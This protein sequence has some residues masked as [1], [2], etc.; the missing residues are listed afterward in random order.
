MSFNIKLHYIIIFFTLIS[1]AYGGNP[2]PE[3][4][5]PSDTISTITVSGNKVTRT[6]TLL[7]MC[8]IKTGMLYDSTLIEKARRRLKES[9]LFFKVD[10]LSLK[11]SEGYRIYIILTEKFYILPYDLG[12]ELFSYR[13][14]KEKNWWRFRLG[15]ENNN[16][17]G[18]AEIVRFGISIWDWH[19]I[20]GGWYKPFLPSP[21]YM[22]ISASADQLP[23]EVFPI[24]HNILRGALTIG[25]YLPLYSRADISVMPLIRRREIYDSA[26]L[27]TDNRLVL[28]SVMRVRE[29]FLLFRWRTDFRNRIFDPTEGWV[30]F[31][32]V[33][34]NTL[35]NGIAPRFWQFYG[36]FRWYNRGISSSHTV[37]CR[38]TATFRNTDAGVTHRLQLGGEGSIRG[39]ARSQFGLSFIA[40]NSLT[41][42][43]EYRF[44]LILFPE[45][46]LLLI[47][48]ISPVFSSVSYRLDGAFILDYGKVTSRYEE[49]FS[50][51]PAHL[52]SGAGIGAGLRIVTPTFERS[53]CFDLV[54]GTNP[55]ASRGFLIFMRYPMWHFY[56][57]MFF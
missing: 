36:D 9:G 54:W 17:R 26:V 27:A 13:Y 11:S 56:L 29:A 32:D 51:S 55:W 49:L 48:G 34:T 4:A 20:S 12:G 37:A 25:R 44:P 22:W 23:D 3:T 24:D 28:D 46:K 52:E 50:S 14:G 35:Y 47:D 15:V 30:L 19:S 18:K 8:G 42:S 31:A 38:A 2:I 7:Y 33:R 39:Y 10:I 1:G 5:F 21:Y 41:L 40:N 6:E 57:D 43:M 45:M 16:F 53:V